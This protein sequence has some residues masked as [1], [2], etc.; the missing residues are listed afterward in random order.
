M[1]TTTQPLILLVEDEAIIAWDIA[2]QLADLGYGTVG[3]AK[4]GEQAI[5]MAGQFRPDLVL[6]DIHLVGNMDGISAA[7]EIRS[8]FN[9]PCVFLSAFNGDISRER[10]QQTQPLGYLSKPFSEDDLDRVLRVALKSLRAN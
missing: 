9:L 4:S 3:P 2:M 10:A 5:E 1:D 6:M 7:Q 8:Q